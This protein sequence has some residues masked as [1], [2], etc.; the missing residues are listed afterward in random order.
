MYNQGVVHAQSQSLPQKTDSDSTLEMGRMSDYEDRLWL[1][2]P[3]F[4]NLTSLT[5]RVFIFFCI[6]LSVSFWRACLSRSRSSEFTDGSFRRASIRTSKSTHNAVAI[7][8]R[9]IWEHKPTI[10]FSTQQGSHCLA[11][12]K[13]RDFSRTFQDAK[14]FFHSN[15]QVYTEHCSNI[16]LYHIR[17]INPPSTFALNRVPIVLLMKNYR[18]FPG[19]SKTVKSLSRTLCHSSAM[20]KYIQKNSSYLLY[21]Y[22]H[23]YTVWLYNL[24]RKIH[25]KLQRIC[26]VSNIVGIIRTFI[27]T[28]CSIHWKHV[29]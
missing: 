5:S 8:N 14:K 12:K 13:L 18:T 10:Y 24:S 29:G 1:H 21:I 27:S 23:I 11:Y 25:H 2:T 6:S 19:L 15:Q 7:L 22:I 9:I 28:W 26:S 20:F 16:E 17:S 4:Q 3:K